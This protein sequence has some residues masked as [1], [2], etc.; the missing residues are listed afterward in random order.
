MV[1][2]VTEASSGSLINLILTSLGA[3]LPNAKCLGAE[4]QLLQPELK[5]SCYVIGEMMVT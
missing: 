4:M 1:L 3:Q 2:R 5:W